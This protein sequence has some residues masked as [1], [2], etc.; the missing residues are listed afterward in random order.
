MP[1]SPAEGIAEPRGW[2]CIVNTASAPYLAISDLRRPAMPSGRI[3]AP[4]SLELYAL[5][6][7]T[8]PSFKKIARQVSNLGSR[9]TC[10]SITK[11][12]ASRTSC[13]IS[14]A[15]P[16]VARSAARREPSTAA[17]IRWPR[18]L[19]MRRC[20]SARAARP[21]SS[22]VSVVFGR[23]SMALYGSAASSRTI[24]GSVGSKVPALPVALLIC[25]GRNTAKVVAPCSRILIPSN[26]AS[27]STSI[28][29]GLSRMSASR[30]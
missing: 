20:T 19:R 30:L 29:P 28:R 27:C 18:R 14:C 3:T 6:P 15:P 23:I 7:T 16:V 11:S 25:S 17:P 26:S 13:P 10:A 9:Y 5:S 22:W 12:D 2:L 8:L 24:D 21:V 1:R 4:G